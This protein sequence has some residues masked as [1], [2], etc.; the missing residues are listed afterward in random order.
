[1]WFQ[2]A[3]FVDLKRTMEHSNHFVIARR[4]GE[5]PKLT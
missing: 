3:G 1:M 5:T 4:G 2:Q